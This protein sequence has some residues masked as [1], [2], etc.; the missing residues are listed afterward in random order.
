MYPQYV[1]GKIPSYFTFRDAGSN[2]IGSGYFMVESCGNI[3]AYHTGYMA[4]FKYATV[5]A[6][7]CQLA[8]KG[9]A[10]VYT[11]LKRI[12]SSDDIRWSITGRGGLPVYE[13]GKMENL[14]NFDFIRTLVPEGEELEFRILNLEGGG[15][16]SSGSQYGSYEVGY[17]CV[18]VAEGGQDFDIIKTIPFTAPFSVSRNNVFEHIT[19]EY[20]ND[21][22]ARVKALCEGGYIIAGTSGPENIDPQNQVCLIKLNPEGD[23]LWTKKYGKSDREMAKDVSQTSE[24]G[25]IVTGSQILPGTGNTNI[26]LLKTD[27]QGNVLWDRNIGGAGLE[28][29][30]SVIET[31]DGGYLIAGTSNDAGGLGGYDAYLIKTSSTGATLWDRFYGNAYLNNASAI[32]EL[33]GGDL[34]M[35]GSTA[36]SNNTPWNDDEAD[37]WVVRMKSNGDFVYSKTFGGDMGDMFNC[38]KLLDNKQV[39]AG[40]YTKSLNP[41]K[42]QAY[43]V[44]LDIASGDL[45]WEKAFGKDGSETLSALDI[46]PD[47]NIFATGTMGNYYTNSQKAFISLLKPNGE[48][49]NTNYISHPD[50]NVTSNSGICTADGGYFLTGETYFRTFPEN[51]PDILYLKTD[52]TM[53][54]VSLPE[55]TGDTLFCEGESLV[56]SVKDIPVESG[57]TYTWSTGESSK[58]IKVTEPGIYTITASDVYGNQKTSAEFRVDM[59][60][61]P[62]VT[63]VSDDNPNICF[64]TS[65]DLRAEIANREENTVYSWL[66]NTGSSDS[67]IIVEREGAYSVSVRNEQFGCTGNAAEFKVNVQQPYNGEEICLVTVD[68]ESGKNMVVFTKT[69]GYR[70]KAFIVWKETSVAYVYEPVGA[71]PFSDP[72]IFIDHSSNPGIQA[73][74]YRLSVLDVCDNQSLKSEPHKTMHLT[75]NAAGGG[76]N[77]NNIIWDHYEGFPFGTYIIYRGLE[78]GVM[79]SVHSIQSTLTSWT[80]ANPPDG[81][82]YYQIGVRKDEACY[83]ISEKKAGGGPYKNSFSNLE[84]N[85]MKANGM[86]EH[87]LGEVLVY[88]NP[89]A[90]QTNIVYTVKQYE[91]VRVS[92][93]NSTGQKIADLF[94]GNQEPADYQLQFSPAEYGYGPGLYVIRIQTNSETITRMVVRQ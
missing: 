36:I 28:T 38:L 79:D 47:G 12:I 74:R 1:S 9:Q 55:I 50:V 64:G 24:G 86:K 78:P 5:R 51:R 44:L 29:G 33:P 27:Y 82:L 62:K 10:E 73:D 71:I 22:A 8:A 16:S 48:L 90:E 88:P 26:Y 54:L 60:P 94:S 57:I 65:I 92:V 7:S 49:I 17:N 61:S 58:N 84:D 77:G 3:L 46:T 4:S 72:N 76:Q 52:N 68:E 85:R 23:I 30:N 11:K 45:V 19:G 32:I 91:N 15:F 56:L 20:D 25:F 42:T 53:S 35:A 83:L 70:T 87:Q 40:G 63:I 43:I 31:T 39:L 37:A 80:D 21:R 41:G 18:K 14:S 69:P 13:S 66:W 67:I 59:I 34:L 81:D 6:Q 93:Y 89:F 2:G 75:V